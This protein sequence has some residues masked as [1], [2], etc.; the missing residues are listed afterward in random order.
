[1]SNAYYKIFIQSIFDLAATMVIKN[2]MTAAAINRGI[3][4]FGIEIFDELPETWK[5]Y[6][7]IAGEYHFIPEMPAI[8]D[9][10]MQVVSIDTLQTID[11]TKENMLIHRA[12]ANAY[13]YGSRYYNELVSRFPNQEDLI[14]G[15][16]NPV[17]IN[18][19]LAAVDYQILYYN[20]ALVEE[21]EDNLIPAVQR[22]INSYSSRW[23]VRDYQATD[24]LYPAGFANL[25]QTIL[26]QAI[27]TVRKANNKTNHVHSYYIREYLASHGHL[28]VYM[29]FLTKKQALF[30]YRNINYIRLNAG[31]QHIFNLL[32]EKFFTDRGFPLAEF[33]LRH[34]IDD[35]PD[36]IEPKPEMLR[37]PLNFNLVEGRDDIYSIRA[38]L[39]KEVPLAK[40][41]GSTIDEYEISI[42]EKAKNAQYGQM[43]SKILESTVIDT[44]EEYPFLLTDVLYN[45]WIYFACTNR[46]QAVVSFTDPSTGESYSLSS[47]DA[48]TLFLYAYNQSIGIELENI[49]LLE[50]IWVRRLPTPTFSDLAY[51]VDGN[52]ISNAF[53]AEALADLVS[54][55]VYLSTESFY[56]VCFEIHRRL[57]QHWF[58][59]DFVDHALGRGQAEGMIQHLYTNA[60][61]KLS[62]TVTFAQWLN[63]RGL[64]FSSLS[65]YDFDVLAIEISKSALGLT[66][67]QS[68]GIGELQDA[69]IRIMSQLSSYTIQF[70][71]TTI[72]D[73]II[74]LDQ[75]D[76]RIGETFYE[77][78]VTVDIDQLIV[79]IEGGAGKTQVTADVRETTVDLDSMHKA[80]ITIDLPTDIQG[81]M[82]CDLSTMIELD[83]AMVFIEDVDAP[84]E[85]FEDVI[86]NNSLDQFSTPQMLPFL[87]Q[88]P[89][90]GD[91]IED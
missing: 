81:I 56:E 43:P 2:P 31:N 42:T 13:Q 82:N 60:A 59:Y 20:R 1:M 33:N 39:E 55:G 12:T 15:I 27:L 79:G 32:M 24:D 18:V 62:D 53:I 90:L 46:Y 5:Y 48:F 34:N 35:M 45:H 85:N 49:P 75:V 52:I 17:P 84:E 61:V 78:G 73:P 57:R 76:V 36:S 83:T 25:M 54:V 38:V 30:L 26:I 28:D 69:M 50:A 47:K 87:I 21:N 41:N 70:I 10:L 68:R 23:N 51:M 58:Q 11:F 65:A 80:D 91:F 6:K 64:D 74:P 37:H 14:L 40:D 71:R 7:N 88:N 8:S 44:S 9:K 67:R 19:A 86:P 4:E 16:L 72:E 63:D 22:W 66:G 89:N 77:L 29:D 3:R